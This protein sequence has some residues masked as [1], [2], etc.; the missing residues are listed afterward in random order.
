MKEEESE[1]EMKE[2]HLRSI[3]TIEKVLGEINFL[4]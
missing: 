2:C 4:T 3:K 1:L